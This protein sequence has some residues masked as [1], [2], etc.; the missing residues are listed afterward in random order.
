MAKTK[1]AKKPAKRPVP[2]HPGLSFLFRDKE[3][4][5][6]GGIVHCHDLVDL[7]SQVN[8]VGLFPEDLEFREVGGPGVFW[9]RMFVDREEGSLTTRLDI[10]MSDNW[11]RGRWQTIEG[12]VGVRKFSKWLEEHEEVLFARA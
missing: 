4:K 2:S 3:S 1:P 7:W 12:M 11:D 8:K 6:V 10:T 9:P 5:V